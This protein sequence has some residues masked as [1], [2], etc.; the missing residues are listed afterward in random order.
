MNIQHPHKMNGQPTG[1]NWQNYENEPD[2]KIAG[3]AAVIHTWC[4]D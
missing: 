3:R 4:E 2:P 1:T